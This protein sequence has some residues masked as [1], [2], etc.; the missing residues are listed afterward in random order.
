VSVQV[1]LTALAV[2]LLI[3]GVIAEL[4]GRGEGRRRPS[5]IHLVSVA[6]MG[7]MLLPV[8]SGSYPI[9]A[10]ALLLVAVG[11]ITVA[12]A[13]G[14]Q[15]AARPRIA[16]QTGE[17]MAT[18]VLLMVMP[19]HSAG[20]PAPAASAHEHGVSTPSAVLLSGVV[21]VLWA[22]GLVLLARHGRHAPADRTAPS[23]RRVTSSACMVAA[24]TAM[25]A[26]ALA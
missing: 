16:R 14:E 9:V 8:A 13:R 1:G 11:R 7:W 18:A 19:G 10:G 23:E 6:A 26:S 22:A 4:V 12:V 17:L 2:V 20:V 3:A 21:L 25:T 24:M 15:A 5:A